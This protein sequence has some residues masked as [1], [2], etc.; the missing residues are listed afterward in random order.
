M[1]QSW[2]NQTK[3]FQTKP[4]QA[5]LKNLQISYTNGVVL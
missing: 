2:V 3:Q 1:V 5:S 4:N